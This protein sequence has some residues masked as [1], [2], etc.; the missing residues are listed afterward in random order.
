SSGIGEGITKLFSILGANVVV[1]GRKADD[2]QRVAK[3]VQDLSPKK[4]KP[5]EVVGD[6]T[7]TEFINTLI[8]NTIKTFGKLD[9]LVNNAA[10]VTAKACLDMLT[11]ILALELGPKG[12]HIAKGVVFLA[13]SDAS[14][15]TGAN[16]VVDGG[17]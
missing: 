6:L 12:I 13:S 3:E 17:E 10:S 8:A 5:L 15:I 16:L 1:T 7:K 11:R 9:V 14:F 2:V 4:L